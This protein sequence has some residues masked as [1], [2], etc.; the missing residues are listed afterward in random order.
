MPMM[1]RRKLNFEN[2]WFLVVTIKLLRRIHIRIPTP[3]TVRCFVHGTYIFAILSKSKDSMSM[4]YRPGSLS[5]P[6]AL[7]GMIGSINAPKPAT[8]ATVVDQLKNVQQIKASARAFAAV[9]VDGSVVT[10]G[11]YT[12]GGD[13]SLVQNELTNVQQIQASRSAFAAILADGSVVTWGDKRRGGD[14]SEVRAHLRHVRRL[15]AT[16][17]AFA[18]LLADGS[19]VT[20]GDPENGGDSS[21]VQDGLRNVLLIKASWSAFAA[22]LA[23]GSVV[24]W[25][26]PLT[27]GDSSKVQNQLRRVQQ[28]RPQIVHLLRSWQ[29]DRWLLGGVRRL[30]VRAGKS[31]IRSKRCKFHRCNAHLV[32]GLEHVLF[33]H[34]LGN[35]HPN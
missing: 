21:S 24:T 19:V 13:S 8:P 10:L 12:F 29:M 20:W 31:R 3:H 32:G 4:A 11:H 1:P 25:G 7:A 27:G 30:V 34:I 2:I 16:C 17:S 26:N 33:F 6:K 23:D 5:Q 14:N 22:I 9:L 35:N 15:E 18:A 28:L